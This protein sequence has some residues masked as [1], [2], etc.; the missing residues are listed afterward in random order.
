MIVELEERSRFIRSPFL[1][2]SKNGFVDR[3]FHNERIS[4]NAKSFDPMK[5]KKKKLVSLCYKN[6]RFK[7]SECFR[8]IAE[9]DNA[10]QVCSAE[11][12]LSVL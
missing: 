11:I 9:N 1:C 8:L 4:K 7:I 10:F 12:I 3:A 2:S 6:K 5:F